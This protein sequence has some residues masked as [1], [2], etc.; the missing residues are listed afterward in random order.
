ML[1]DVL[2][3]PPVAPETVPPPEMQQ[4][5]LETALEAIEGKDMREI[6]R[7]GA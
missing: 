4:E 3:V 7:N 1:A 2:A 5:A 6:E